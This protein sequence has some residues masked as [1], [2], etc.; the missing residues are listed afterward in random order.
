MIQALLRGERQKRTLLMPIIFSLG[1][2]LE[3][4]P[5]RDF[6]S[7]PTKIANALRQIRSVLKVDGL[8]CYFDP[9]LEAEALGCRREWNP[10][11]SSVITCPPYSDLSDLRRR[12]NAPDNLA[13]KGGIRVACDVLQ[14]L[15]VMLQDEPALMVGVTGPFTLAAQLLGLN[16]S[17]P[18][19]HAPPQDLVEFAV[20]VTASVSRR[21][22]ESG[23]DVVLLVE[24]NLPE[25]SSALAEWWA[26]LLA[27]A[28]NVIRFYEAL[29]V[30][31]LNTPQISRE[32][33]SAIL[34]AD[35][36]CVLCPAMSPGTLEGWAGS[37]PEGAGMAVAMPPAF[38]CTAKTGGDS[39]P[40]RIREV[41]P[42]QILILL[43]SSTDLPAAADPKRLAGVLTALRGTV[44][45]TPEP[46]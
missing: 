25:I 26:G 35:W 23:A 45:R 33:L 15:K 24:N 4:L 7:N 2:R 46:G 18:S 14:R 16:E 36:E 1:A 39:A 3:N 32:S 22:V 10:E 12:L 42:G 41:I 28:I 13:D 6:Q 27:P 31:L 21:F 11:G 8:T 40:A 19:S 30:L 43:T 9:L 37:P 34:A 38:Y 29:P 44:S 5:L 17:L 20:E